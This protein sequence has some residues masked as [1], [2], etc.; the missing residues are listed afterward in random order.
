[1]RTIWA[2][3]IDAQI[4]VYMFHAAGDRCCSSCRLIPGLTHPHNRFHLI[5]LVDDD[6]FSTATRHSCCVD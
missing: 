2:V 5:S 3:E 6:L 1:M 4:P